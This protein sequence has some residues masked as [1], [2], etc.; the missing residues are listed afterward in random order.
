MW[1]PPSSKARNDASRPVS[2]SGLAT[3]R[4]WRIGPTVHHL[5]RQVC[6]PSTVC[7][8]LLMDAAP[9]RD[10]ETFRSIYDQHGRGVYAAAYRILGDPAQAQDVAQDVF[11]KLWRNPEKFDSR[12]GG[13]GP[14]LKLMGRSRALDVWREGQAAGRAADRLE[15][16]V[17]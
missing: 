10:P 12:R 5:T 15:V 16:V 6:K 14:Y 11:L 17:G 7:I 9:I 1:A 8:V 13:L 3:R 4:L 2:R